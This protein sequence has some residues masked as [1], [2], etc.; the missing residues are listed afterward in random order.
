MVARERGTVSDIELSI[1]CT[2][3]V[4]RST[5]DCDDCLVTF[6]L[7]E[8]PEELTLSPA[9]ADVAGLLSS[10]GMIPRLKFSRVPTER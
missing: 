4:R 9:L 2:E 7:G 1:S 8:K 5:P 6:V 10:Q 3:C